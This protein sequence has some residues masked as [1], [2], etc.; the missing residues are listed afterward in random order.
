MDAVVRLSDGAAARRPAV[1]PVPAQAEAKS[2]EKAGVVLVY[3]PRAA[4]PASEA[5]PALPDAARRSSRTRAAEPCVVIHFAGREF[6]TRESMADLF[7]RSAG[8]VV[9]DGASQSVP[10]LHEGGI[11]LLFITPNARVQ[12][13]RATNEA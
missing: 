13:T 2:E 12:V 10:L 1:S 8:R 9:V 6:V 3:R 5:A 11:D 7:L 4:V